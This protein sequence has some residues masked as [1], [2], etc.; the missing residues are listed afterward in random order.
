[1]A[2]KNIRDY[3]KRN[4][5]KGYTMESLKWALVNQGYTRAAIDRAIDSVNK[6][7]AEKAPL[8]KEKPKITYQVMDK[9]DNPVIIKRSFWRRFLG[10]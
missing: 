8:L 9:Y 3:I 5:K 10:L 2:N 7:L 4:L 1:M 6:E